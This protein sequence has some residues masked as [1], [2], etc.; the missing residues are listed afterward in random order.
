MR[1][2][3][4]ILGAALLAACGA[5]KD[6]NTAAA[7]TGMAATA[8]T[9]ATSADPDAVTQGGGVPPGYLGQVDPPREGR[10][11]AD[12]SQA[13][14]TVQGG[15]WEV[16]TGP[17]HIVYAAADTAAGNYTV[18][19][20]VDQLEQPRHPEA[21]GLIIG[22][23]N[24]DQLTGQTYTYFIVRH[25]GEYMVRVREGATTRTVTEW[26]ASPDVPKSADDGKASYKL[27][28][29]VAA[30]SVHF[31]VNDKQV[32]AV[33]R[34]SVPS[35]GVFGMRINHSLHLMVTPPT[36]TR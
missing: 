29:R 5:G 8:A 27:S 2:L 36:V 28:A 9:A 22:G 4:T 11:P 30:D 31:M 6:A 10:E 17:A 25:T 26:T 32:A 34:A 18:T 33:A 23:S 35:A 13:Q 7:D 20:T 3:P 21:F 12:I 16:T 14:Y 1:V 24:L 19:S 15:R